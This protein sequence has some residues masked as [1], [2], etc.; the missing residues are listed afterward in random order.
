[1]TLLLATALSRSVCTERNPSFYIAKYFGIIPSGA[2][3]EESNGQAE[4]SRIHLEP[5]ARKEPKPSLFS[6]TADTLNSSMKLR[7]TLE[8]LWFTG[9][10]HETLVNLTNLVYFFGKIIANRLG[11]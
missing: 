7:L 5:L 9:E 11:F 10:F 6:S 8:I 1:M 2:R 4:D 3:P